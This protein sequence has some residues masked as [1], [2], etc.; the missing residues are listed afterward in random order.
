[1]CA[2]YL[3]DDGSL[4]RPL[5]VGNPIYYSNPIHSSPVNSFYDPERAELER[6]LPIV[7]HSASSIYDPSSLSVHVQG[8]PG[9][10]RWFPN[11]RTTPT[12]LPTA[13]ITAGQLFRGTIASPHESLVQPAQ[14]EFCNDT[15]VTLLLLTDAAQKM[16][17]SG[18]GQ[19]PK[20]S[21]KTH[22]WKYLTFIETMP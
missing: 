2:A 11:T 5:R 8:I 20:C 18:A 7:P 10:T 9:P 4:S 1:M 19:R 13:G 6:T 16:S 15:L 17:D 12:A 21:P 3:P 14:G 22:S